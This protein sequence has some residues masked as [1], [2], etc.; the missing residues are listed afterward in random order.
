MWNMSKKTKVYLI[1]A[2]LWTWI[3]WIG[4]YWISNLNGDILETGSTVFSLWSD[5]YGSDRFLPQLIFTV[6]VYGPFI[7]FLVTSGFKK[8]GRSKKS[9]EQ[10]WFY[11]ILIPLISVVPAIILS[12]ATSLYDTKGLSIGAVMITILSYFA[13]NLVTSGTEEF[14]W[15]GF[16]YPEMK[17]NGMSF[18]DIAWKG[19]FVW[20]LWH[21]PILFILYMPLGYAVLI[22]SL[23]GFT[24]SIV[25]MNYITNFLYE[26]MHNIWAVVLLHALNNT[27]SFALVLLFPGTPFTI[28]SSLMAWG[29][30]GW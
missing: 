13:S 19:G 22:P 4:A 17:A 9:K 1:I 23:A 2:F 26:V 16:L 6:A 3:G 21:F 25:A 5:F 18:W 29:I 27:M 28:L 7:G 11:V 15:R 8:L 14:G 10:F 20:A 24:A 12:L 30:V